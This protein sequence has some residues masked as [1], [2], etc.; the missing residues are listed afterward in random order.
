MPSAET[1]R[2]LRESGL[3]DERHYRGAY[4]EL[5][6]SGIDLMTHYL[7]LGH[8]EG[9]NPSSSFSTTY[10]RSKYLAGDPKV[11]PLVHYYETGAERGYITVPGDHDLD[12]DV[13]AQLRYW[14]APGPGAEDFDPVIAAGKARRAK[15]LA[16]YL[17]QF[18]A[19]PENDEWWGKGFTEW[20]NL[21]RGVPRFAGHYQPRIPRDLGFYDLTDPDVMRR[22]VELALAAGLH[23][24]CFYYY[25]FNGRRVLERPIEQLLEDRS[26]DL[27]FCLIWANENWTR[28]W[29]GAEDQILLRQEYDRKDDAGLIDD[30]QRHFADPRYIRIGGRPVILIYRIGVVPT[31]RRTLDR[32]RELWAERH[33]EEPLIFIAQTFEARDPSEY[34]ADGAVE[35]PPHKVAELR[36]PINYTV[37]ILDP[38]FTGH[39]YDYETIA[40]AGERESHPSYPL[41]KGVV[42][43]WDNDARRQGSGVVLRRSSPARYEQWLRRAVETAEG[44]PVLGERMVFINA[45]NEWAEGAY[46][47]PDVHFG[48]AY[49]NAT[50]RAVCEP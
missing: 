38:G 24:F 50:A 30:L 32:W 28:R 5:V 21:M 6:A 23:G 48:A 1:M 17:P 31:P 12:E 26:L 39:I 19:I 10:Y 9:R 37:R 46:L 34:G 15:L 40:A 43:S 3:F 8:R 18:H 35:F 2:A 27:P 47:E 20:R 45:W 13:F 25:R 4:P 44:H 41:V 22:Q 33:G 49:L 42:P 14:A 16:F 11:N 7:T 29:D 36:P